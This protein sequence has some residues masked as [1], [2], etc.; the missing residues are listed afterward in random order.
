M[1]ARI[2]EREHE[3]PPTP[4]DRAC[5][6]ARGAAAGEMTVAASDAVAPGPSDRRT[7]T[8]HELSFFRNNGY[9]RP[10]PVASARVVLTLAAGRC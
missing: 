9:P 7:L 10:R 5:E 4:P 2:S 3:A 1:E 6:P 8:D